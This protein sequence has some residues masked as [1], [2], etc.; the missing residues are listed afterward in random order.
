MRGATPIQAY[1]ALSFFCMLFFRTSNGKRAKF[2]WAQPWFY[3]SYPRS[4]ISFTCCHVSRVV[5]AGLF[6]AV[7]I[8]APFKKNV[9]RKPRFSNSGA[10][11]V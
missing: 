6:P 3:I 9:P 10:A 2:L 11:S 8:L 1:I 4:D 5:S 7:F